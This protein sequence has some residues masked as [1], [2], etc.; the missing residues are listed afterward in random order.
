MDFIVAG[1]GTTD[2]AVFENNEGARN[3][4]Q[5]P[6]CTSNSKYI[7]VRSPVLRGVIFLGNIWLLSEFEF[8]STV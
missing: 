6:V 8:L 5:N 3:L 4:V 7:D 1:F 2:I